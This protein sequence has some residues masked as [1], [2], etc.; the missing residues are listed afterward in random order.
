MAPLDVEPDDDD[1]DGGLTEARSEESVEF[2]RLDHQQRVLEV[3][4]AKLVYGANASIPR[5]RGAIGTGSMDRELSHA[6][7]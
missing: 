3:L 2:A 4:R 1:F 6:D 7:A 5:V